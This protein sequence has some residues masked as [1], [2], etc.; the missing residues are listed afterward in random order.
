MADQA[1]PVEATQGAPAGP[2]LVTEALKNARRVG[3]VHF[4]LTASFEV[5]A[6]E[7][8]LRSFAG[9]DPG[10]P[11]GDQVVAL[12]R[13]P[14]CFL[15][16]GDRSSE[17]FSARAAIEAAGSVEHDELRQA[18]GRLYLRIHGAWLDLRAPLGRLFVSET[19]GGLIPGEACVREQ[20]EG[21]DRVDF[22][23]P[24]AAGRIGRL[25]RG[26]VGARGDLWQLSGRLDPREYSDFTEGAAPPTTYEPFAHSGRI[27]FS[28]GKSDRLPHEFDFRYDFDRAD[29]EAHSGISAGAFIRRKGHVNISLSRWGEQVRVVPPT[30]SQ[31]TNRIIAQIFGGFFRAAYLHY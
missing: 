31:V 13:H 3:S 8:A 28:A 30:A 19:F 6:P 26:E 11:K 25:I 24:L 27:L 20:S 15:L 7:S 23:P 14:L 2:R 16:E 18:K 17:G 21:C 4:R 12:A 10:D 22:G 9:H 1:Q 29:I 5:D